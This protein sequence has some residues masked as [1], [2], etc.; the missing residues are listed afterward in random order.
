MDAMGIQAMSE[1]DFELFS[2][3]IHAE[4]GIF[5]PPIKRTMLTTRLVKRLRALGLSS[6]RSYLD[7]VLSDEGREQELA[8]M[9]DMVSTNKTE[10]FREADHFDFLA[11]RALPEFARQAAQGGAST[12]RIWSAGCSTG[13]EPY[14]IAMVLAEALRMNTGLNFT[15]LAT[16]I[17]TRVL[18]H[19]KNAVYADAALGAIPL[20]V[21][22]K[23]LMRGTGR[24]EGYHR[25]IPEL[26]A[27]VAFQR[28]N[29]IDLESV[30]LEPQ[31][32]IFCRNVIIYFNRETQVKLFHDFY[33]KL[34]PGG[35]LFIGHSETL[36]GI[37][38]KFEPVAS[39]IYRRPL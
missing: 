25:V 17:S 11:R 13:E 22:R 15:V 6:F 39:T 36:T 35:L 26:R 38:S 23:Y 1:R 31:H 12:L 37:C 24:A 16:D 29:L 34:T 3:F 28:L 9:L 8:H 10:F 32:M 33:E 19:A 5:L 7:Y 18:S 2:E 30:E 21:R 27:K 14:T 20:A 4:C